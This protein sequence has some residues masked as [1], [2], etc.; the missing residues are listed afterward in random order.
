LIDQTSVDELEL[1]KEG[2]RLSIRKS[3]PQVAESGVIP[4]QT[5]PVSYAAPAMP[6]QPVVQGG[7]AA[8]Q[9]TEASVQPSP[10]AAQGADGGGVSS[11][12]DDPGLHKIVSPMV[13]TFYRSPA[14]DAPAFVNPGDKVS[15]KT[16]VC[17]VE[18]M[19][20]MNEIEAEVK[21]EIVE[22]LVE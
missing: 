10:Q 3:K 21:G 9:A 19:K 14:P 13:G 7:G 12:G 4:V 1:E 15:D 16:V 18:A 17:I 20:L 2:S 8:P 22:V 5:V 11:R 6:A